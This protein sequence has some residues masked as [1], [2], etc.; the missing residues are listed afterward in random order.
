MRAPGGAGGEEEK[1][2]VVI[3]TCEGGELEVVGANKVGE[4]NKLRHHHF[5]MASASEEGMHVCD[6]VSV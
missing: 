6:L 5:L 3:E 4:G 2:L 1:S